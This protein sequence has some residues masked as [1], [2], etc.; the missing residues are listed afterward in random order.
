M[1]I[2]P[3]FPVRFLY[4]YHSPS[5]NDIEREVFNYPDPVVTNS[6]DTEYE[7]DLV[8]GHRLNKRF[9]DPLRRNVFLIHWKGYDS[10]HNTWEPMESFVPHSVDT[11]LKFLE[12]RPDLAHL[13]PYIEQQT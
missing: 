10:Q 3:V 13:T 4:H 7:I 8:S 6:G 12:T 1:P 11:L 2:H 5:E 9:K